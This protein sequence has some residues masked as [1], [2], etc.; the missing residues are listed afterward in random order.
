[1][2]GST[3]LRRCTA[4]LGKTQRETAQ[5]SL[6]ELGEKTNKLRAW[7]WERERMRETVKKMWK[8]VEAKP[9]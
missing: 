3:G 4:E 9:Q 2:Q 7:D 8:L 5:R 1:M 6:R